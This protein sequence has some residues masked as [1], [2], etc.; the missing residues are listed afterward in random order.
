MARSINSSVNNAFIM[1]KASELLS[2]WGASQSQQRFFL[3]LSAFSFQQTDHTSS[4]ISPTDLETSIRNCE[5]IIRIDEDLR[6]LFS[7]PVNVKGYMGMINHNEP[8]KG[9]SP[10]EYAYSHS[11]GLQQVADAIGQFM[12]RYI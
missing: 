12:Y 6:T 9:V 1:R 5:L 10:L 4:L 11:D 2:T 8:Y 7:N 3:R